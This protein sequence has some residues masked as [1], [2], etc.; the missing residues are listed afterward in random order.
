MDRLALAL[1]WGSPGKAL[2]ALI[3]SSFIH[4]CF[5]F[6]GNM[7]A[8]N[9]TAIGK[10]V[11][12]VGGETGVIDKNGNLELDVKVFFQFVDDKKFAYVAV[13]GIGPLSG[14]PLDAQ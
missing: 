12:G 2:P 7:T 1:G 10:V 3:T 6:S 4:S 9:G 13:S 14:H 5:F 8:P 11:P